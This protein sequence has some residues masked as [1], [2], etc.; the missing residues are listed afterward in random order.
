MSD[1]VRAADI[2]IA[3]EEH[4]P[5]LLGLTSPVDAK[6]LTSKVL[7]VYDNLQAVAVSRAHRITASLRA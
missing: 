5:M 1:M 7:T 4:L 3:K 6:D 2:V